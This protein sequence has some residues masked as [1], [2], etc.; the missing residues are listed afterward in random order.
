MSPRQIRT[1]RAFLEQIEL[2]TE[3]NQNDPTVIELKRIIRDR[4]IQSDSGL[5]ADIISPEDDLQVVYN[6]R[7]LRE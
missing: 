6:C 4:I 7:F 5:Q 3:L 1:D 2:D